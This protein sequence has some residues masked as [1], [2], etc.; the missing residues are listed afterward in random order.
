[1]TTFHSKNAGVH[2][3]ETLTSNHFSIFQNASDW[4]DGEIR[5]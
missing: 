5:T 2:F 3:T 1:M 4:P